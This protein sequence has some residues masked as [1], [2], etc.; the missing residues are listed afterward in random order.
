MFQFRFFFFFSE[1]GGEEGFYF[2][3][4]PVGKATSVEKGLN[5]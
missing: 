4:G 5:N 2:P 1:G 3:D